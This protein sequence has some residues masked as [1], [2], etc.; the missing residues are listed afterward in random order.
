MANTESNDILAI[1]YSGLLQ[2]FL[3]LTTSADAFLLVRKKGEVE[4]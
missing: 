1:V 4:A 3:R 2:T